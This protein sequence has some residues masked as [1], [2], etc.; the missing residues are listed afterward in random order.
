[1]FA[2]GNVTG[3]VLAGDCLLDVTVFDGCLLVVFLGDFGTV[4]SGV[5]AIVGGDGWMMEW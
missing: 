1:M 2:D 5:D 3:D 4:V